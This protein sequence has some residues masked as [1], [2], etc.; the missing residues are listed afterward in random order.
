MDL[1]HLLMF[2]RFDEAIVVAKRMEELNPLSLNAR[3]MAGWPL[4]FSGRYAEAMRKFQ[5]VLELDPNHN[6]ATHNLGQIYLVMGKYD[7]AIAAFKKA[8]TL[9]GKDAQWSKAF[10]GVA[11]A[12]AGETEH[13]LEVIEEMKKSYSTRGNVSPSVI[14]LL[15]LGLGD[16]EEAMQWFNS[17][18]DVRDPQLPGFI[19]QIDGLK[20]LPQELRDDPRFIAM[21]KNM[22]LQP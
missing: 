7:E 1:T 4:V 18:F 12:R 6:I 21:M 10:L 16:K 19:M 5:A 8:I 14:A 22:G 2:R 13:A 9:Y 3:T 11:Y 20:L 17:A 15:Y